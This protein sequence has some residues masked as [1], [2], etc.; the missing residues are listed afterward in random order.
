M[1]TPKPKLARWRWPPGGLPSRA[2]LAAPFR[3]RRTIWPTR[4]GWWLLLAAVGLGFA[5]MNTGNNLLYLLVSMLLGLIVVSGVLSERSMRG[6]AISLRPPEELFAARPALFGATVV[7]RKRWASSH[8]LTLEILRPDGP[9]RLVW[10][11]RLAPGQGHVFSWQETLPHRGRQRLRGIRIT[12]LFP[13]GLFVKA[14]RALA[15]SEVVVYPAVVPIPA[16]LL[17]E[18]G[19]G[20]AARRPGRGGDLYNLREYRWGDDPRLIHWRSTAKVG[21]PMVRE[22]EAE[23]TMDT[24]IV[25]EGAGP[26]LEAGVS[27]AASLVTHLIGA[28]SLVE[29]AGPGVWVPLGAGRAQEQRLL[30]ALALYEPLPTGRGAGPPPAPGRVREIRVRLS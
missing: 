22:L 30:T 27:R 15:E 26:G 28:G 23:A 1:P 6:L 29:L 21:S 12:T 14:G 19:P 3:P 11:P 17:A 24:R 13:F 5:A 2:W 18:L 7:N 10:V 16:E 25:L 4:E 20:A 8:S 9:P